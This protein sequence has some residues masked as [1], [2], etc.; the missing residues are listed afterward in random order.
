MLMADAILTAFA[1]GAMP[2]HPAGYRELAGWVR[3][4]FESMDSEALRTLR[5]AAPP[6]LSEIVENVLHERSVISWAAEDSV[7]LSALAE[8][9]SVLSACRR[10][11]A[12]PSAERS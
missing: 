6:E 11:R 3:D 9:L 1:S 4:S 10:R 7:G 8:C 2:M 12:R 5:D